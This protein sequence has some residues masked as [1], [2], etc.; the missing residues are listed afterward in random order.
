[1]AT[2]WN[3]SQDDVR[4]DRTSF[5][6]AVGNECALYAIRRESGY[7]TKPH[8]HDYEQISYIVEGELWTFVGEEPYHLKAGDFHRVP[9][10]AIHWSWNRGDVPCVTIE[11]A[12]PPPPTDMLDDQELGAKLGLVARRLHGEDEIPAVRPSNGLFQIDAARHGIDVAKVEELPPV[13]RPL[14]GEDT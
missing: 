14:P 7:H 8:A 13:N 12:S 10:N 9:R 6:L 3:D 5:R 11:A 4:P 2:H 1:M